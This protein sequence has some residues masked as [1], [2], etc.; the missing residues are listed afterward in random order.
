MS[1]V[2]A[3]IHCHLTALPRTLTLTQQFNTSSPISCLHVCGTLQCAAI[4][5]DDDVLAT[6]DATGRIRIYRQLMPAVLAAAGHNAGKQQQQAEGN[7]SR[8]GPGGNTGEEL[9]CT[10][11]H[12]HAH[13]VLCLAFGLD[14]AYLLSGGR[15]A[16]L[17]RLPGQMSVLHRYL[18]W[19]AQSLS[20]P[21]SCMVTG[22]LYLQRPA[23]EQS[24]LNCFCHHLLSCRVLRPCMTIIATPHLCAQEL[25]SIGLSAQCAACQASISCVPSF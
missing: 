18:V 20:V 8:E 13:R 23:L 22:C 12:W 2:N 10:T 7:A 17:V 5:P 19:N 1:P 16:V 14:G 4:S 21:Q 11:W 3:P 6:G 15:E 9:P 24:Q 25:D